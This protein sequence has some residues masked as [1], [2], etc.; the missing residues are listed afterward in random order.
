VF[1]AAGVKNANIHRLRARFAIRTIEV[2]VE[3]LF[4]DE[5]VN[6]A[7]NWVETILVKAAELMGHG[8]PGSLR[9]YLTYVLNRRLQT[10]DAM[11]SERLRAN[12]QRMLIEVE[13][14]DQRLRSS[15]ELSAVAEVVRDRPKAGKAK[16]LAAAKRLHALAEELEK[17]AEQA[18]M[19]SEKLLESV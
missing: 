7:S 18:T 5:N 3:G 19:H 10:S 14:I 16:M 17:E 6:N 2:L 1:R 12:I 11:T 8:H 9:P 4:R 13:K 15:K